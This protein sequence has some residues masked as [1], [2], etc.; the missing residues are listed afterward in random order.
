VRRGEL[1]GEGEKRK[2]K[3]VNNEIDKPKKAETKLGRQSAAGLE[4]RGL[5]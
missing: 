1:R 2:I 5:L 3:P 4:G